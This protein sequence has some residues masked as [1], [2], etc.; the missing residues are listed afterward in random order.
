MRRRVTLSFLV[1]LLIVV[2][3]MIIWMT[4]RGMLSDEE[5]TRMTHSI[6]YITYTAMKIEFLSATAPPTRTATRTLPPEVIATVRARDAT[7]W[8]RITQA[9]LDVT[10]T[11]QVPSTR[12][13]SPP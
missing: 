10:K 9:W 12:I 3:L 1:T 2:S 11:G 4:N 13:I 7:N 6:L 8:A 5:R